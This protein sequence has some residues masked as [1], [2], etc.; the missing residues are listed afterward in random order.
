MIVI[1]PHKLCVWHCRPLNI[2]ALLQ[3]QELVVGHC[4]SFNIRARCPSP[5][6]A[7]TS[8]RCYLAG[9]SD[10]SWTSPRSGPAP[11]T[12]PNRST[13][14]QATLRASSLC[15]C[16]T[17][18]WCRPSRQLPDH[19]RYSVAGLLKG[20]MSITLKVSELCMHA[21]A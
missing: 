17:P 19:C 15:S 20:D 21:C 16:H 7:P 14:K 10:R 11:R 9:P 12:P 18:M 1:Q 8:S 2:Q 4:R 13:W 3:T 5:R 6:W